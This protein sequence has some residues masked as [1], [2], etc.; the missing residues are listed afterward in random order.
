H[1]LTCRLQVFLLFTIRAF[2]PFP[3][4][5]PACK[6]Q[7]LE[8]LKR[9]KR[10]PFLLTRLTGVGNKTASRF[11]CQPASLPASRPSSSRMGDSAERASERSPQAAE[12]Q[13]P[14][15]KG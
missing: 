11:A 10:D 9:Q 13:N 3:G 15:V 7:M 1:Y 14:A 8:S 5:L 12:A 2:F 6:D 4:Q